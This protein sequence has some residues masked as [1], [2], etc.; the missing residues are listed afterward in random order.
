MLAVLI[1]GGPA[2]GIAVAVV[3]AISATD[4]R[5]VGWLRAVLA[6]LVAANLT[7]A[8]NPQTAV[9]QVPGAVLFVLVVAV[10]YAVVLA[11]P[12]VGIVVLVDVWTRRRQRT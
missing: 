1:P 9:A 3:S 8:A 6:E 11:I 2:P 12:V 7:G 10:P 4:D 5:V